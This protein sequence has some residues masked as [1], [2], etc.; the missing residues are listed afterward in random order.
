[1][2]SETSS[3]PH[4]LTEQ[5]L[6]LLRVR[7]CTSPE[8]RIPTTAM[9]TCSPVLHLPLPIGWLLTWNATGSCLAPPG[10][11]SAHQSQLVLS[12]SG[13]KEQQGTAA[14]CPLHTAPAQPFSQ[15]LSGEVFSSSE[16]KNEELLGLMRVF[17]ICRQFGL[18]LHVQ[19]AGDSC[20]RWC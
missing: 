13:A 18:A 20:Q 8:R 1:M 5:L 17:S 6:H 19:L 9:Q 3:Q 7:T 2:L 16:G 11:D 10:L 4:S 14:S 12:T 15:V